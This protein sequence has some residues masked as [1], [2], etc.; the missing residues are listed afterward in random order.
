[1]PLGVVAMFVDVALKG[2]VLLALA[3]L[4]VRA[5][6]NAPAAARHLVWSVALMGVLVIPALSRTIPWKVEQGIEI[7]RPSLIEI[8]AVIEEGRVT[9]VRVGGSSVLVS[10]GV[11]RVP[12]LS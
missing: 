10:R 9:T 4:L 12:D 8:E 6:P 7:G 5:L 11:M 3:F 2:T 1:M